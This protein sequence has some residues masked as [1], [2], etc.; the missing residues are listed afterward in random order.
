LHEVGVETVDWNTVEKEINKGKESAMPNWI[1]FGLVDKDTL[2]ES[3][4]EFTYYA[5]FTRTDQYKQLAE[6][7]GIFIPVEEEEE[8]EE[9]VDL[10]HEMESLRPAIFVSKKGM[11]LGAFVDHPR[12][13]QAGY[14]RGI[15]VMM[16]CDSVRTEPGRKKLHVEDEK[17]ARVVA[18]KIFY[19]LTKFSHYIIPRDPDVEMESLLRDVNKNLELV[20]RYRETKPL[21]N[22]K[23]K[24]LINI[25]PINEQTL[26]GLFH[27]LIG[28][29]ILFGYR[30]LK[31]SAADTYDGIYEYNV[32]KEQVGKEY[33]HEWLR[34]YPARERKEIENRG[35]FQMDEMIVEFKMHL[36]NILKDFLQKTKYHQHIKLI[37]AWDANRD[38]IRKKGWLLEDLPRSKQKFYGACWRLRPSAEGQTRGIL[39]TDVL[40]LKD[41]LS[42]S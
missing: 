7:M 5:L 33:W 37:V 4:K 6:K 26:I 29:G 41:F 14:W 1:G 42:Q 31:L 24:I 38:F 15:F 12:T 32:P 16:N 39:A 9:T 23:N 8:S 35:R 13:G 2:V 40:L 10:Q 27:E 34:Q 36:E 3:G 17:I 22:P 11:P 30:A 19:K 25:E 21:T 18:K 20:R 28:A